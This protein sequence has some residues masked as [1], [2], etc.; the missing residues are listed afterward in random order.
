MNVAV[1]GGAGYVGLVTAL[2]LAHMGHNVIAADKDVDRVKKLSRG[3]SPIQERGLQELLGTNLIAERITF[4]TD[5]AAAVAEGEVV[6]ITVD[7]PVG[8]SGRPELSRV[9]SVSEE[10]GNAIS[11]YTTVVVKSTVPTGAVDKINGVLS[12]TLK[13]GR[14]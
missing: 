6:F 1:V 12:R 9:L 11:T 7:T 5:V 3:H 4:T 10:I 8:K 14:D 13:K 2:G